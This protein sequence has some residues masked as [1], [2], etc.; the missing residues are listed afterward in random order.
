MP[1]GMSGGSAVDRSQGAR[2]LAE[3]VDQGC[4]RDWCQPVQHATVGSADH[5]LHLT[6]NLGLRSG[7][8]VVQLLWS[9][10]NH[11]S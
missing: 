5:A 10:T 7:M 11:K 3:K 6:V 8:S 9:S 4:G 2:D 1:G